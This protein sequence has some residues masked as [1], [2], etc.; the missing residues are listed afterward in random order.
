MAKRYLA[1]VLCILMFAC[2]IPCTAFAEA[3]Y[4]TVTIQ[5][6]DSCSTECTGNLRWRS[7]RSVT[8]SKS[9]KR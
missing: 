4:D 5:K 2:L 9:R 7:L 3:D 6:N 1:L 8:R